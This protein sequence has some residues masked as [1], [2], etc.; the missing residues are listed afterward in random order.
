MNCDNKYKDIL[1]VIVNAPGS[2]F[3]VDFENKYTENIFHIPTGYYFY[4]GA[5]LS[6]IGIEGKTT[7]NANPIR[8]LLNWLCGTEKKIIERIK[9]HRASQIKELTN[10]TYSI[11]CACNT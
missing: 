5:S 6:G 10:G 2:E 4:T 11:Q 1:K 7:Y 8:W 9:A 3:G